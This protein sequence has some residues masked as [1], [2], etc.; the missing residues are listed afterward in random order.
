MNK[1]KLSAAKQI[2]V[3]IADDHP[4]VRQGFAAM[5]GLEADLEVIGQAADGREAVELFDRLRPDVTLIDLK[6]PHLNGVEA[7]TEI[8]RIEP[9]AKII[10]L[11]TFDGDEDIYRSLRAG[12]SGYLLK[13]VAPDVLLD[14]IRKVHKG[15]KNIQASM[16]E[17]LA[18]R[19]VGSDLTTRESEI[20]HLMVDGKSNL[21]I[22]DALT[23]SESTVKF[24]IN[25]IF[26][27][28]A[29]TDRPQAVVAAIKRGLVH[30]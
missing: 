7:I 6:M 20:L 19:I 13:D 22:A 26:S 30:L 2:T 21:Q 17:K 25:N 5:V 4:V 16:V 28:L 12:A 27:K 18:D 1:E 10:V 15:Q 23:I 24:H 3:I 14:A 8:R 9:P 29:V 11:T